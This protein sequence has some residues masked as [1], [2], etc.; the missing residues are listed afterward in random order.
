MSTSNATLPDTPLLRDIRERV[1]SHLVHSEAY[2]ALP[3]ARRQAL[4]HDT[5]K[6]FAYILGGADGRSQPQSVQFGGDSPITRE[7]ADRKAPLPEGDSAGQRFAESGAVAAE[8][9][10]EAFTEM[11]SKV[12]FPKFVAGLIDGVF[13]AIVT[14][15]IK[16]MEAYAELVA[17]VSKSVDQYMKDNVSENNARDYLADR[18][19]QVF[20]IGFEDK[21]PKLKVRE[22]FD[23]ANMPDFESD[24][25]LPEKPSSIDDSTAEETLL[26][27]ARR[28]MAMDRQQ[29]LATMVMMGVNRLV[30]TNGQIEASCMFEL[31]T[32]DE[33]KR[34]MNQKRT[35]D[36]KHQYK[37]EW[38]REGSRSSK[39]SG[40]LGFGDDVEKKN[41]WYSK[42][43]V[44]NTSNFNVTTTR[45]DDSTAKVEMHAKLTGK[46]NLN[47]K[48]DYFPMEK[49]VDVLQIDRIRGK[50]PTAHKA[51][52]PAP[53]QQ[54]PAQPVS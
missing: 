15:S 26:P 14:S 32:K 38:G 12:N 17:N 1:R 51:G 16:Q 2:Q 50:T 13:N 5:V 4:A 8:E 48:S 49:M 25:G 31:D 45:S 27:A 37:G 36:W 35:S 33:V 21:G 28:R 44:D 46:V 54:T 41:T 53:A 52:A 24:L 23:E 6:A 18:Y 20:E 9:G 43:N 47:F 39:G 42:G 30:V 40:F 19:P 29:L 22:G 10:S 11:I 3:P 7:L 34:R